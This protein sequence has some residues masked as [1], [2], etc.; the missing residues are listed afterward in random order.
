MSPADFAYC[1]LM[2]DT[3]SDTTIPTI[4]APCSA[5]SFTVAVSRYH[6]KSLGFAATS[7]SVIRDYGYTSTRRYVLTPS[8]RS[9]FKIWGGDGNP[10]ALQG[11]GYHLLHGYTSLASCGGNC[12]DS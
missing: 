2:L 3:C 10:V 9:V 8:W 6:G 12:I 11:K 5:Q 7:Y 1:R 4:A